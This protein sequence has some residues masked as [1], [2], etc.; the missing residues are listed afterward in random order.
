MAIPRIL[1]SAQILILALIA[2]GALNYFRNEFLMA[3]VNIIY[4]NPEEVHISASYNANR[5]AMW[6]ESFDPQTGKCLLRQ[7]TSDKQHFNEVA[8]AD[9][10]VMENCSINRK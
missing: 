8:K 10:F 6:V 2:Y 7:Y 5:A 3:Q 9:T 4:V 1:K